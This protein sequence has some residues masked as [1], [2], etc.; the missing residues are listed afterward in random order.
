MDSVEAK[1]QA[2]KDLIVRN[3]RQHIETCHLELAFLSHVTGRPLTFA[4][5]IEV[6]LSAEGISICHSARLKPSDYTK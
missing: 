6:L 1:L 4:L 5:T 2:D 3:I